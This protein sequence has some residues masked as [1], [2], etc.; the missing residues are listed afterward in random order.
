MLSDPGCGVPQGP[1][2]ALGVPVGVAP[3]GPGNTGLLPPRSSTTPEDPEVAF[4]LRLELK[5]QRLLRGADHD[6]GR[7]EAAFPA[8]L[9]PHKSFVF[10]PPLSL[11]PSLL[12]CLSIYFPMIF[13]SDGKLCRTSKKT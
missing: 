8:L 5:I 2:S 13:L 3:D 10:P 11:F 12:F 7:K 4:P 1:G 9:S 6:G